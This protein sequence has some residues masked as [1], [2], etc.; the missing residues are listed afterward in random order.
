MK[1]GDEIDKRNFNSIYGIIF[2]GV[3]NQG[4]KIEQWIPM[5]QGQPNENLIRDL[6]FDSTYLRRLHD[7][8]RATFY[9]PDSVIVSIYETERTRMPRVRILCPELLRPVH[10]DL[11]SAGRAAWKMDA[12]W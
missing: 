10:L 6:G 11:F 9:F 12:N 2:F 5:V 4:I 1:S 7:T 3:P 8:F